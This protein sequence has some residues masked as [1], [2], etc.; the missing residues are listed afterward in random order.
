MTKASFVV[1]AKVRGYE[2]YNDISTFTVGEQL[3]CG[4][5]KINTGD[6][7][8]DTMARYTGSSLQTARCSCN[9]LL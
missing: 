7:F 2:V 3:T 6:T 4:K 5:E 9:G 1:E 8:P